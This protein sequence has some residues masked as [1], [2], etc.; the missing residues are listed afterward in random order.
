M[1]LRKPKLYKRPPVITELKTNK[2]RVEGLNWVLFHYGRSYFDEVK[3]R[4][5]RECYFK[6][7]HRKK[8][9][10]IENWKKED[11]LI[12]IDVPE[13]SSYYYP[14]GSTFNHNGKFL[15][16]PK[17]SKK[18]R[19]YEVPNVKLS[20][21]KN[22]KNEGFHELLKNTKYPIWNNENIYKDCPYYY[23]EVN[24]FGV[25][26]KIIIPIQVILSYFFYLSP[27]CIY[28]ILHRGFHDGIGEYF[29]NKNT[30][31]L[32]YKSNIIR[33]QELR[34]LGKY[35]FT[36]NKQYSIYCIRRIRDGFAEKYI[37]DLKLNK[38]GKHYLTTGI[39][40]KFD[41]LY[42]LTGLYI[43]E[44]EKGED[45]KFLVY[46]INSINPPKDFNFFKYDSFDILDLNDK[47]ST[48]NKESKEEQGYTNVIP[49]YHN[50][51]NN[52][53]ESETNNNVGLLEI[54][55][56]SNTN[57]F[58]D[59]PTINKIKRTDQQK[60]YRLDKTIF[61]PIRS[62]GDNF[63]NGSSSSDTQ[64]TNET[65]TFMD[66]NSF[67]DITQKAMQILKD[68]KNLE[69]EI[70]SLKLTDYHGDYSYLPIHSEKYDKILIFQITVNENNYCLIDLGYGKN[71]GLLRFNNPQI[72][73]EEFSDAK[74]NHI[75]IDLAKYENF[76]FQRVTQIQKYKGTGIHILKPL[77]HLNEVIKNLTEYDKAKNLANRIIRKINMD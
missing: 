70:K 10:H 4:V 6:I 65:A 32:P 72:S 15:K 28:S 21:K 43:D 18:D 29:F 26:T 31:T 41:F 49:A 7:A 12:K 14:I 52:F 40:F 55:K 59:S 36:Y 3:N 48:P 19:L 35:V 11:T 71:I 69:V 17:T 73:F 27:M 39:P 24:R 20:F 13:E 9:F 22:Y 56:N 44:Y 57:H 66:F 2:A 58:L 30:P 68:D 54:T 67:F 50:L 5:Y 25:T 45:Q 42:N 8:T 51:E 16:A 38:K 47:R 37:N 53:S 63:G 60:K 1:T 74:L 23:T 64:K 61:I 62:L 34:I 33:E 76:N 75:I 77:R 46:K